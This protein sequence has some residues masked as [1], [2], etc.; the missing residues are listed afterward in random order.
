MATPDQLPLRSDFPFQAG[1]RENILAGWN[2]TS[3][4]L[5]INARL[6][7]EVVSIEGKQGNF[8]IQLNH[9]ESINAANIVL[10]VGVQGNPNKIIQPGGDQP[11]VQYQLDDP[12]AFFDEHI[13][14]IGG[15][16]AGIENA[17]GLAA[18]ASQGLSLIHI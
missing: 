5:G 13:I 9:G 4:S 8:F 16:D 17:L 11:F 1:S 6:N 18:D 3:E 14:V 10:A 2:E 15:G 12:K 7:T